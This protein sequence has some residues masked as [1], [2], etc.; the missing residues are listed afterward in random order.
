MGVMRQ[1]RVTMGAC[2][3]R[4][5]CTT[6][7]GDRSDVH[8]DIAL[9]VDQG[10]ASSGDTDEAAS[11]YLLA[12]YAR[13]RLQVGQQAFDSRERDLFGRQETDHEVRTAVE[14]EEIYGWTRTP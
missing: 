6:R 9:L 2:T 3:R 1:A 12:R 7:I 11:H 10:L 14:L 4:R 8:V 13:R 5:G